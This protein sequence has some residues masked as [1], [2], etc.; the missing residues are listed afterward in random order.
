MAAIVSL[1]SLLDV[2]WQRELAKGLPSRPPTP[3]IG[4]AALLV[5]T[6]QFAQ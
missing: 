1:T 4:S 2:G 5:S 6:K 3:E